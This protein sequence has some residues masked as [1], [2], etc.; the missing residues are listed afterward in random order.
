VPWRR[1][2]SKTADVMFVYHLGVPVENLG[3]ENHQ[4]SKQWSIGR[5]RSRVKMPTI[6]N[7]QM[8]STKPSDD[9]MGRVEHR[10]LLQ[11]ETA[12]I[13]QKFDDLTG[14]DGHAEA[15][16]KYKYEEERREIECNGGKTPT[17]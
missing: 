14:R 10:R 11:Y 15:C 6:S 7:I 16:G 2:K 12:R 4:Q 17:P 3:K 13:A 9:E 5:S 8:G 1:K